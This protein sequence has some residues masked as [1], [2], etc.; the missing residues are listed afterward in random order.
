MIMAPSQLLGGSKMFACMGTGACKIKLK[1]EDET[2]SAI[3]AQSLKHEPFLT[4]IFALRLA[5]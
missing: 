1:A 4:A 5:D 2:C 3:M